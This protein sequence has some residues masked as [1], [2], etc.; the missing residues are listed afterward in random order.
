MM[1]KVLKIAIFTLLSNISIAASFDDLNWFA[2]DYPPFSYIGNSNKNK[3]P[4][5]ELVGQIMQKAGSNKSIDDIQIRTFSKMF[6]Y[7][8]NN[9]NAVFFPLARTPDRESYFKWVGPIFINKPVIFAKANIRSTDKGLSA[10]KPIVINQ[11]D[12]LKDYSIVGRDKYTGVVQLQNAGISV[13]SGDSDEENFI[14]LKEDQV[15]MIVCDAEVGEYLM[16]KLGEVPSDYQIVYKLDENEMNFA[17]NKDTD[18]DLINQVQNILKT[19]KMK[20]LK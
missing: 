18:D 11:I 14:S 12:D 9:Q 5:I 17:F 1:K 6:M 16:K 20:E 7:S 4:L 2:Q 8:N 19:T 10:R 13:Q 3:G 15:Q